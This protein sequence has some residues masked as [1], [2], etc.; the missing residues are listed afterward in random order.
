MLTL[1]ARKLEGGLLVAD[2]P[3]VNS[4]TD[5]DAYVLFGCMD[6][7]KKRFINRP[8]PAILDAQVYIAIS[9]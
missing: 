5:T 3:L 7:K 6:I 1:L 8:I 2:P 9:Y 4:A